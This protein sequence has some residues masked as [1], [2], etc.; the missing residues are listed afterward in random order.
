MVALGPIEKLK[1]KRDQL[2]KQQDELIEI[3]KTKH[4]DF[5]K[6]MKDKN[7]DPTDLTAYSVGLA[8]AAAIALTAKNYEPKDQIQTLTPQ[9][10]VIETQELTGKSDAQ[11]AKLVWERYGHI[12]KRNADKYDLEPELI[13]ATIMIESGG[14]TYAV[15]HEPHINDAS[16]GLGQ[17]LYGTARSLDFDGSPQDLFDPEVNIELTARYHARNNSVYGGLTPE[18]LTTTYNTGS[19]YSNPLPGHLDK[20]NKWFNAVKS[21]MG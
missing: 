9:V 8:S 14:N 4:S 5:Y 17:L 21:Y 16:Y 10:N 13:F 19:P 6:W 12:I 1:K 3:L 20:F 15:R 18:E 2:K 7:I 11:K